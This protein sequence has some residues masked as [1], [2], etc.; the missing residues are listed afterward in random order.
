MAEL[1]DATDLKSVDLFNREGSSPSIPKSLHHFQEKRVTF[2]RLQRC[3]I[4]EPSSLARGRVPLS[5]TL[6]M[7]SL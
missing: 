6:E 7:P 5:M 2:L 3:L 4:M 1:V